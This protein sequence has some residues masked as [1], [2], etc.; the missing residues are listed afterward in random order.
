[1][2]IQASASVSYYTNDAG[3]VGGR[4]RRSDGGVLAVASPARLGV[5]SHVLSVAS[6]TI[7]QEGDAMTWFRRLGALDSVPAG[8]A[9]AI[10][11]SETIP[12]IT[13]RKRAEEAL[14]ESQRTLTTLMGNLPGAVYRCRND[15]DVTMIFVSEGIAALTGYSASDFLD[16]NVYLGRLVHPDDFEP[17]WSAIQDAVQARRPYQLTYRIRTASG[18]EK[19]MWEQG[20]G[21]FAPDG[22]L[23]FLEGFITD[24]T[25]RRRFE[26]ALREREEQLHL[27]VE[28]SPAAIAMFDRDM[29]YLAASRRWLIDFNLGDRDLIGRSHYEIFPEIPERWKEV[30]RRCLAGA[31]ERCEEDPFFRADGRTDWVRWEVRPWRRADGAI[32]GIII[33]TEVITERKSAEEEWRAASYR[34]EALVKALGQIVYQW[35]PLADEVRWEGDYSKV[36][37]YSPEEIG[38]T[39]DSWTSRVHPDDLNAVFAEAAQ[40]TLERR[41]F[42]LHYRFRHRNGSYRWMHDRGILTVNALGELERIIGVF[43]DVTEQKEAEDALQ[44]QEHRLRTLVDNVPG[45]VY[46]CGYAPNWTIEF[47][48]DPIERMSGYPAADFVRDAVRS[49]V[50]I[51]EPEDWPEVERVAKACLSQRRPYEVEYRIR[52]AD[53]STRWIYEK[54]QGVFAET[55]ELRWLDG[56][57]VDVTERKRTEAT[58]REHGERL[59]RL[60]QRLVQAQED[61]AH[62]IGRELHDELGQIL[63][64]LKIKLQTLSRRKEG[65]TFEEKVSD[66]TQTVDQAIDRIRAISADLRPTVLDDLG[67]AAA[68]RWMVDRQTQQAGLKGTF[69]SRDLGTRLSP[70]LETTCYRVAQEAL[71][72]V[73][74]HAR[75]KHVRITLQ[76]EGGDLHLLVSDDGIGFDAETVLSGGLLAQSL[77]VLGMKERVELMGGRFSIRSTEGH[78]TDVHAWFALSGADLKPPDP[79]GAE[80]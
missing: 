72:N 75:A 21:I 6:F 71:T 30:H 5:D 41:A 60:T 27:F 29:R 16:G 56:V 47:I 2:R 79:W 53:G 67:L 1:M 8:R 18:D 17:A 46:R 31:V 61:E 11:E 77:G 58:L 35:R 59:Q 65:R 12:E 14:R 50:S 23:L 63:T 32:G 28:H 19:W 25:E 39:T 55:G 33:F 69:S 49:Y 15:Q 9:D 78:G 70:E 66:L 26:E 54:G 43:S 40:A 45:A 80:S 13:E 51:I 62:R 64:S 10:R 20:Q 57:V 42:D 7:G 36:L 68:L 34:N 74:R 24:V 52:H 76:R 73:V 4:F 22:A 38:N 37:G 3:V 48:S 44:M